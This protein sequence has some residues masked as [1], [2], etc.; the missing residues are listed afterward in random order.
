MI[1]DILRHTVRNLHFLSKNSTLISEKI[2]DFLWE[3]K[4]VKM[5][6]FW[7]SGLLTT[8]ISREKLS[9]NF[10]LKTRE[11]VGI[12]SKLNFWTKI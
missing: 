5:L 1:L 6:W 7:T 10:G 3:K 4:F 2:V 11:N 12:L 9:K 8:L